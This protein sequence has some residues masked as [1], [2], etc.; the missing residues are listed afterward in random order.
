MALAMERDVH[1]VPRVR[2]LEMHWGRQPATRVILVSIAHLERIARHVMRDGTLQTQN[3]Q[4]ARFARK[5]LGAIA[6]VWQSPI[7]VRQIFRGLKETDLPQ[8]RQ[9]AS[10]VNPRLNRVT[11]LHVIFVQLAMPK[12]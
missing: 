1:H 7:I 9:R 2:L 8:K 11:A 4:S 12:L 6:Q 10:S 3:Q 5:V